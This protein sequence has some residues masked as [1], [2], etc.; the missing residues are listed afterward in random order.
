MG[1]DVVGSLLEKK[2]LCISCGACVSACKHG[3]IGMEADDNG[4]LRAAIDG[5][6]VG[7]GECTLVCPQ[8]IQADESSKECNLCLL[9]PSDSSSGMLP[10]TISVLAKW[11]VSRGGLVCGPLMKGDLNVSLALT[12]DLFSMS[13]IQSSSYAFIGTEGAYDDVRKAID[14]GRE[15]LFIGLPCQVRAVK[16]FVGDSAL[17]FTADIACKG[18]PS[19]VIYQRYT[20]ELTSDKPV[21]S[22]RFEPK[23]KPDGTLEVSYE[24]GTTSTSYDSPYMKA[25]DRN[26]IVNQA[27]VACRIPGRS[28]TGD[29]TIGDAEKFKMLTVGLKSPEKA[30][31]FTS[32]TEK[33]EVIREGVA[34]AARMESHSIPSK[35]SAKPKNEELHL[36][37]IRMMRMVNRGVPFDKAVGYCMK[38]RFDV[39]IA[40]P[41]NSDEHGTVLSYYA[42]YDMMGDMGMEPIMLDRRRASKGAPASPK[43]LKKKYPF[44]SISKWYPDAQS[45]AELNNRVVRFVVGPGRVWKDGASDPDGVSFH[46]L[47]FVDDGK[48]M[49][50]ISS[51]LSREDEEQARPFVDAL[52]RFNG[53]SASDNETASFLKGCGADAE[54]VLD[55]VLMCDFEH[56]E[57]LADS[58]EILLPEQFVFNYVMEPE[59]FIGMESIYEVLG[60]GPISIPAPGPNAGRRSAYPMT[61]IGS[62]ENWLRCL[63]DS[64]FVLTDSYYAVLFAILF[65]KPFIAIANGQ[66]NEAE[67]RKISWILECLELEDRMFE[68][69]ADA[70]ASN[71]V[72]EDIDYDAAYEIL[73]EMRE[74][75]LKWVERVLDAP[76]SLLDRL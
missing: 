71:S 45:Q 14:S 2:R 54:F 31:T 74:R 56:L 32:N 20:E 36:G 10:G 51:S 75:S 21:R 22:I 33:G 15:V 4:F 48:R 62:S 60:Y 25:L 16:A 65:R 46:T 69:I 72:R 37:W 8:L 58:S 26:L 29:I 24:D 19:P 18:Q 61:D 49:A 35:R 40:G 59:N 64:S 5:D 27:C 47:D 44:Y 55:P 50:S 43:I 6:C 70:S 42:L 23:G 68:S 12:D 1:S 57:A 52:R 39:G 38:W 53:V 66:R 41:W 73:G 28:G 7:C 13:K 9:K 11:I 67:A 3:A 17:L 34:T 63:R 30:I 76:E